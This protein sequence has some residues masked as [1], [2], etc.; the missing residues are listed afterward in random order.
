MIKLKY[1]LAGEQ[2]PDDPREVA[3][4]AQIALGIHGAAENSYA[5][6]G[7]E[8]WLTGSREIA[9]RILSGKLPVDEKEK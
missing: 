3:A 1:H 5:F 7:G 4:A 8:G 9:H 2:G 6:D